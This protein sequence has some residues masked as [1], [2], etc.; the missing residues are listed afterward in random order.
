MAIIASG[1]LLLEGA[2]NETI[3][4]LN[5]RI[6]SKVV[7]TDDELHAIET[8]FHVISSHLVGGRHAVRVYADT[9]PGDGFQAVDSD[10]EDVY[11]L[12]LSELAKRQSLN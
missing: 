7:G 5:G 1:E 11:F 4:A 6:W 10:L 2:P 12:N 9:A 3:G 8:Q